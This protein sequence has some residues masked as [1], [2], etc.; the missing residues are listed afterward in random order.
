[1]SNMDEYDKMQSSKSEMSDEY[2]RCKECGC[3]LST[4]SNNETRCKNIDCKNLNL[5]VR[6]EV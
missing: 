6:R 1:M 5:I 3:L 2:D 4:D